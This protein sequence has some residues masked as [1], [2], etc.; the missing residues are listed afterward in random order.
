MVNAQTVVVK[1][2]NWRLSHGAVSAIFTCVSAFTSATVSKCQPHQSH[3]SAM[4]VASVRNGESE[5]RHIQIVQNNTITDT[6]LVESSSN[7]TFEMDF[8]V[9]NISVEISICPRLH[10]AAPAFCI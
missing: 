9:F 2:G 10:V 5:A 6:P 7:T 1:R 3:I 8:E 4:K